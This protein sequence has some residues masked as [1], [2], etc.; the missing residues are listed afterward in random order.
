MLPFNETRKVTSQQGWC[1]TGPSDQDGEWKI[2][3][4]PGTLSGLWYDVQEPGS[5]SLLL[6][7]AGFVTLNWGRGTAYQVKFDAIDKHY[8]AVYP[9]SG[10]YDIVIKGEV[11]L[12]TEFDSLAAPSLQGGITSFK[13]LLALEVLQ[14]A[15]SAV[16]GDIAALGG[17][18]HLA[19]LNLSGSDVTGDIATLPVALQQLALQHTLV[20]GDLAALQRLPH[21]KKIDL[22]GTLAASYSGAL[23]PAW[24]NGIV[25]KLADLHLLAGDIDQLLHDL[26]ATAIH[27]G[28]LDISGGN[29]RRTSSSNAAHAALL[30]RGWTISCVIGYATFGS[31]DITFGDY[32]ARFE[33]I[34]A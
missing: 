23:L 19:T 12:I 25:L 22:S 27:N 21:L 7:G 14:L 31:A 9:A 13:Y 20:H 28:V 16:C 33:E 30:A 2:R 34:A 17:L 18:L 24:A 32:N 5:R 11:Q 10:R 3:Q 15:G 8:T 26:A 1:M 29:G 6:N 4:L